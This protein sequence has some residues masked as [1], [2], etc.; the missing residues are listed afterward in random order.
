[1]FGDGR[2]YALSSARPF[3]CCVLEIN[4]IEFNLS[5][6]NTEVIYCHAHLG[7]QQIVS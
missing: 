1:M 4:E 5:L 3:S 7:N 6:L 2:S